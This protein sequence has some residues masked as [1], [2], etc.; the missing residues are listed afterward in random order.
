M[1]A[2][3]AAQGERRLP[4]MGECMSGWL[5]SY[6]G[7]QDWGISLIA[8]QVNKHHEGRCFPLINEKVEPF[9]AKNLKNH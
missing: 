4:F 7:N 1:A 8:P 6:Q 5:I 9:Q 2:I 3:L